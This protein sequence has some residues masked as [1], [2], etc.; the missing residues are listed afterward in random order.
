[1]RIGGCSFAFGPKPLEE[2]ARIIHHMGF[3]TMDLGACLGNT[4]INPFEASDQPD[5]V[6][7]RVNAVLDRLGLQRG[8]CFVLDFGQPINHPD[9]S[10]RS[11]TRR[12]FKPLTRFA[13][14]VGCP[15]VMLI[16]GIV[17][18][19]LGENA[20]YDLSVVELKELCDIAEDNQ[21]HLNIEP[22]EPSVVQNPKDAAQI[23]RDVPGLGLTLDYSH[24][25]DPGYVQREIECLHPFARHFHARQAAPGKRVESVGKGTIDFRRVLS[26][27]ERDKYDGV[28][29][30]EYVECETTRACGVNVWEETPKMK[31]ELERLM[32]Q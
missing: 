20:S 18:S 6:A 26:L 31:A 7:E 3:Q 14:I 25:I 2:A 4:Q 30:V 22:C 10:V 27:L 16:P 28:V 29:A 32:N 1:M 9:P 8:E 13:R 5:L 17:H 19:S 15:S 12:R 21:I 11:E 24:F 23:C